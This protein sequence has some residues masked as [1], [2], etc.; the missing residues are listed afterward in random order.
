M[1]AIDTPQS[2]SIYTNHRHRNIDIPQSPSLPL[3]PISIPLT[4]WKQTSRAIFPRMRRQ[5]P[6]QKTDS[7]PWPLRFGLIEELNNRNC[8]LRLCNRAIV[9]D[10]TRACLQKP[11][12][13]SRIKGSSCTHAHTHLLPAYVCVETPVLSA[14]PPSISMWIPP[15][16]FAPPC[17]KLLSPGIVPI[18]ILLSRILKRGGE[19]GGIRLSSLVVEF[20][21]VCD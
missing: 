1:Q 7:I 13:G 3:S 11:C 6:W 21:K 20:I 10:T 15:R 16:L 17:T 19:G 4:G 5:F 8:F 2:L 12:L 18:D 14:S 9:E